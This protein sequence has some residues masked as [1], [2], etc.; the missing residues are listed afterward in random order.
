MDILLKELE[1]A[2]FAQ[3]GT[4]IDFSPDSPEVFQVKVVEKGNTGWRIAVQKVT[5]KSITRLSCHPNTMETFEPLQGVAVLVVAEHDN[6]QKIEAFLLDKPVCINRSV[7]HNL[8]TLSN[9]ALVKITENERV[10]S[11]MYELASEF[12]I[13]LTAS[14]PQ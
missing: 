2:A 5:S 11:E 12:K 6:P 9:Y 4:I 8:I 3:Y 7:W 1:K 14:S 10:E 13:A